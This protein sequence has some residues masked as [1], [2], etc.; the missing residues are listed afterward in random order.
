MTSTSPAFLPAGEDSVA[1]QKNA[2]HV[3]MRAQGG[4]VAQESRQWLNWVWT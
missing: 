3:C 1:A 2:M 4:G